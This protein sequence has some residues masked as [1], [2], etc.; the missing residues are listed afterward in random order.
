MAI[1]LSLSCKDQPGLI[2]QLT[3][4]LAEQQANVTKLEEHV[5]NSLFFVRIQWEDHS[6][7]DLTFWKGV[8]NNFIAQNHAQARFSDTK[9]P[10]KCVLFCSKELHCILDCLYHVNAKHIPLEV[11]AIISNHA[12]IQPFSDLYNIPFHFISADYLSREEHESK[13][14]SCLSQYDYDGIG[15]ARYMRILS[16]SFLNHLKQP[17][18]N[19]HHSFLPSF[20]GADPYGQAFAKGVKVIGATSHFVTDVLDEGPIIH[21]DIERVTHLYKKESL[22]LLGQNC[23][24]VV[25]L[26]AMKKLAENKLIRFGQKTIVFN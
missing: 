19:V 7:E 6:G 9:Y 22:K 13:M 2:S 11:V 3:R 24:K 8:F 15:L 25:F 14:L 1:N 20:K 18:I 21:Q 16:S 23:E 5:E 17:I 12:N 10:F 26:E 4:L